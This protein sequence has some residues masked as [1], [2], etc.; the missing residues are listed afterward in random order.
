MKSNYKGTTLL[1]IIVAV[2]IM[3]VLAGTS[4]M[5]LVKLT[6]HHRMERYVTEAKMVYRA[7]ELYVEDTS[8]CGLL[9]DVSLYQDILSSD[10][11]SKNNK[12]YPYLSG[13]CTKGATLT[14]IAVSRDKTK[15][16]AIIYS[17]GKYEIE[18]RKGRLDQI[19]SISLK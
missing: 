13:S 6:E 15:L 14:K 18:I 3:T 9:D 8:S 12:L 17:V 16:I 11:N 7:A 4:C 1:E 5:A 2:S 19:E 10:V